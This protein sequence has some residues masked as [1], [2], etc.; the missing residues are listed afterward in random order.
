M[1][2]MPREFPEYSTFLEKRVVEDYFALG[3]FLC[4][5]PD[6]WIKLALFLFKTEG[7]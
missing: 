5:P 6:L 2:E 4:E 7:L 3:E 1:G